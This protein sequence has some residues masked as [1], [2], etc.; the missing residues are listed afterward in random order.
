MMK[1]VV[2]VRDLV[3]VRGEREVLPGISLDVAAGVTGLLGP[4]GCGKTTLLR[5]IAGFADLT[6][7]SISLA[8]AGLDAVPSHKRD[9]GMVFQ[10]Y[11]VFPHLTVAENVAFGLKARKVPAA[12]TDARVAEALATVR[13][14]AMATRGERGALIV[15]L[16]SLLRMTSNPFFPYLLGRVE[17]GIVAAPPVVRAAE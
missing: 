9:I 4:S 17:E 11:A 1:N 3:V 13:L 16:D 2:E 14:G 7:G 10:D 8:G 15:S 6:T 5:S 12:E